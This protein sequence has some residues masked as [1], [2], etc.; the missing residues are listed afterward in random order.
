MICHKMIKTGTTL[1]VHFE[2]E[3][4]KKTGTGQL[5]LRADAIPTIFVHRPEPKRRRVPVVRMTT[6][7]QYDNMVA[8]DHQYCKETN[9]GMNYENCTLKKNISINGLYI[10]SL[11]IMWYLL[12]RV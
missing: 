9:C 7:D 2:G 4:F 3:A 5:R 1:Q 6:E 12:F 10:L 8:H 11:I